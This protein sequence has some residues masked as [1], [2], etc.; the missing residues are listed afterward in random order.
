MADVVGEI[1]EEVREVWMVVH[2]E[3]DMASLRRLASRPL[4]AKII[5]QLQSITVFSVNIKSAG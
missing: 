1:G 3:A 5:T 4:H 2:A